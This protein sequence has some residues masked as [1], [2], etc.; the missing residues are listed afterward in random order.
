MRNGSSAETPNAKLQA[1]QNLNTYEESADSLRSDLV[2]VRAVCT[3]LPAPDRRLAR[4]WRL[5]ATASLRAQTR[6]HGAAHLTT[7]SLSPTARQFA[8][9]STPCW[10]KIWCCSAGDDSLGCRRRFWIDPVRLC[11]PTN[12]D[13]VFSVCETSLIAE[14]VLSRSITVHVSYN[15]WCAVTPAMV[16]RYLTLSTYLFLCDIFF[17]IINIT[18]IW[19]SLNCGTSINHYINSHKFELLDWIRTPKFH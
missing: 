3:C 6:G 12:A 1:I 10:W 7:R 18:Q 11:V 16:H 13:S 14:L 4:R 19:N 15:D 8:S 5:I 9:C 17:F 2:A